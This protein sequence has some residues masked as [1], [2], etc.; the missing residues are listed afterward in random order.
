MHAG[1]WKGIIY[2]GF[3]VIRGSYF[4]DDD[5]EISMVLINKKL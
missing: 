5:L 4:Y 2:I 1:Y 3:I